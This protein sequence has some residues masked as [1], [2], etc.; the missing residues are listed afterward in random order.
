MFDA[1]YFLTTLERDV[2][3]VGGDP[4]VDVLL[5]NGHVHRLRSVV[6]VGDRRVTVEAYHVRGDLTH[7]L[8]RFGGAD[9]EH[10]VYR[11]VIAYESIA[12]VMLDPAT[13]HVRPHAGFASL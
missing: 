8:P 11:A 13:T 1:D 2:D 3:A 6:E 5:E 4:V 10:E 12:A 7:H 9:P